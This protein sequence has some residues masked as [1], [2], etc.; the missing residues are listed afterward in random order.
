MAEKDINRFLNEK[1]ISI[2]KIKNSKNPQEIFSKLKPSDA[3]KIGD[4]LKNKEATEKL[5]ESPEVKALMEQLFKD[6]KG[7]G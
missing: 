7:N 2:E 6:G 1:G 3:K 4:L 5:L